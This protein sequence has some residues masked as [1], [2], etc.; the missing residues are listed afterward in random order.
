MLQRLVVRPRAAFGGGPGDDAVGVLDVAGLAV[1][2]VGGVDLQ[3]PPAVAV[4]DH[5]INA[6]RTEALAGVA[7]LLPAALR[8][9]AGVGDLQVHRLAFLVGGAG[10][11]NERDAIARRQRALDPM[12]IWRRESLELAQARPV[13]AVL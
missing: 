1:H 9:D 11:Q 2:A 13:G 3:A 6:R 10:E 4:V 5:L 8:A 7:E 12:A